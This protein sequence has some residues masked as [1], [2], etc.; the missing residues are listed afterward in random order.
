MKS[1]FAPLLLVLTMSLP[2]MASGPTHA[3]LCGVPTTPY[4]CNEDIC[5]IQLRTTLGNYYLHADSQSLFTTDS[6][7]SMAK[8]GGV[9]CFTGYIID[10]TYFA[11]GFAD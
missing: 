2:A 6:F 5:V 11:Q 8:A 4:G 10:K 3:D 9:Q 7:L 1:I